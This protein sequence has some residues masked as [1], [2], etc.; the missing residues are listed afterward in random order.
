[1]ATAAD[2]WYVR[3]PDGR[4]ARA[5]STALLRDHLRAGRIPWGS[6]VRRPGARE[7]LP[8]RDVTEF[9]DAHPTENQERSA[10]PPTAFVGVRGMIEELIVA[11]DRTL[12]RGK[13]RVAALTGVF[14]A[15]G[16][17]ALDLVSS[18]PAGLWSVLGYVAAALLLLLVTAVG[19]VL[20][21]QMTFVELDRHR[22]ARAAE[23]LDGLA[24]HTLRVVLAHG[25]VAG[26]LIG[27]V[28]LLRGAAPW[29]AES[30]L[31]DGARD[32]LVTALVVLRLLI[33]V[34]CW[35]V[36]GL[37]VLLLGPLLVIEEYPVWM[38]LREWAGMVR[39]HLGRIYLYE[40]LALAPALV[41]AAPMLLPVALVGSSVGDAAGPAERITLAVLGGL[42]LTPAIAY[43]AVASVFIY[44]NLRYE[45]FFTPRE[46]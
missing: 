1:M 11:F 4:T 28:L 23:I 46:R 20:L 35:P 34:V 39:R 41:L 10:S 42:A 21:T 17:I 31:G 25:L 29:V 44:L 22:P 32:A 3:L 9:A 5:R 16:L 15:V 12:H 24:W 38:G 19:S 27:L 8:L 18:F 2:T 6:R 45:F 30:D 33:E 43:L 36:L 40:A 14:G 26:V 7:W 13:L 37:A